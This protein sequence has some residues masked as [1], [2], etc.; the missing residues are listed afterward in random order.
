MTTGLVHTV[1]P[2]VLL[3]L[4]PLVGVLIWVKLKR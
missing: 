2:A 3:L 1:L 4:S